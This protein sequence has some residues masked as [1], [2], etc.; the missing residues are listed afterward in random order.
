MSETSPR[1]YVASGTVEDVAQQIQQQIDQD[2]RWAYRIL[3]TTQADNGR[4]LS[5]I[6]LR[7][8][9]GGLR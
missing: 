9:R 6:A 5:V 3:A 8:E 7:E 2:G 4:W 1:I